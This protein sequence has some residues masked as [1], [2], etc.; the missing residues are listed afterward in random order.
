MPL[1]VFQ[2]VVVCE[3][4]PAMAT[5]NAGVAGLGVPAGSNFGAPI[6][7]QK[8]N[9][10]ANSKVF[11]VNSKTFHEC[12]QGKRKFTKYSNYVGPDD[13]GEEIRVYARQNPTSPVVVEDETTGAMCY[14]RYGQ[15]NPARKLGLY[16]F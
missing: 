2:Y 1:D 3:D 8:A 16:N 4:A 6:V 7:H 12:L 15:Q 14:L 11:T 10:F 5:G 13:I 9:T